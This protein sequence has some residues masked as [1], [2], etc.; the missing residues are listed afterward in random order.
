M[1]LTAEK[2][3]DELRIRVL[4][5][6]CD[7]DCG[8]RYI[9]FQAR[10][11]QLWV[12]L[13]LWTGTDAEVWREVDMLFHEEAGITDPAGVVERYLALCGLTWPALVNRDEAAADQFLLV[14]HLPEW[15]VQVDTGR[16]WRTRRA[17][18]GR[19]LTRVPRALKAIDRYY[20]RESPVQRETLA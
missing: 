12:V 5:C 10:H 4:D 2:T 3:R 1:R 13:M 19:D 7:Q 8:S 16:V 11:Q 6:E 9:A 20:V 18:F 14:N 15:M 17:V